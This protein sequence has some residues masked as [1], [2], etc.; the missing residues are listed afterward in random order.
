MKIRRKRTHFKPLHIFLIIF[1]FLIAISTAY[2]YYSTEL[3]INGTAAGVQ[4]QLSVIYINMD[5]SSSYPNSVGYMGTFSYAFTIPPIIQ[6]ITMGGNTLVLNTDY[7]YTNG[8]LT[9]PDVTGNLVIQGDSVAQNVNVSFDVDGN[10]VDTVTIAQGETV[11]KPAQDPIKDGYGFLGWVDANDAYFDF[12]TPILTDITLYA[13]W[14]QGVVAEINGTY[15]QTLQ[16]AI[17]DVPTDNTETTIKIL[18]NINENNTIAEGKNIVLDI[19]SFTIGNSD[20]GE[21]LSI[22]GTLKIMNGKIETSGA[23]TSLT[24]Y[25]TGKIIITGGDLKCTGAKS[26]INNWGGIVEISGN[27]HLTSATSSNYGGIDRGTI[28]NYEDGILTITGGII[29]DT[30]GIGISNI[31][32]LILG[33]KADGTVSKTTP[34]I[35]GKTYGIRNYDTFKFYD[36]IVKGKTKSFYDENDITEIEIGYDIIKL[37]ESINNTTYHTA[38]LGI[39][40]IVEFDANGG[41]VSETTRNAEVGEKIGTLPTPTKT[42]Y[43]FD[44]WFTLADGGTEI[45][46]NTIITDDITLY[47]HWGEIYLAEISGTKYKTI[48]EAVTAAPANTQTT[49]TILRNVALSERITIN[50]NKNIVLDIQNFTISNAGVFPIIDN[51]GTLSISN[52]TITSST[53]QGAINNKNG[54]VLNVSGGR[55]IATGTRQAI[56]NEGG[57]TTIS[58]SAYLSAVSTERAAVQNHAGTINIIGGTIVST[59]F[60]AVLNEGGKTLNIGTKDGNI[61]TTKPVI[62]GIDY[63]VKNSGTFKFYDGIIKGKTNAISGTIADKETN[64]QVVNGTEQIDGETY[65]TAHLEITP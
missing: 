44:G 25:S 17:A 28:Q 46:E 48:Q 2:A 58:G 56:Y 31:G 60:S 45:T 63:G 27:P 32:T 40:K 6:S 52:G 29:E 51:N 55:I 59:G 37:E 54:A 10:I 41:T 64:S 8:T 15:Y 7:T 53:T 57:T 19:Q 26:V 30:N 13:K 62:Q 61:D 5:N 43:I 14:M 21:F 23:T 3:Y 47:A 24:N 39:A 16:A 9:I 20:G 49:I 4:Q 36:G 1:V 18:T 35:I 50:S 34:V 38:H 33:V 12:S 42:N 11:S 65:K 22:Y